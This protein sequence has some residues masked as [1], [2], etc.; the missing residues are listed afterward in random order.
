MIIIF[1][2]NLSMQDEVNGYHCICPPAFIGKNCEKKVDDCVNNPCQNA[3]HCTNLING[4]H[5]LCPHGFSGEF[6][7]VKDTLDLLEC[8]DGLNS[9]A[10]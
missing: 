3:G 9:R 4:F 6:C 5:C 8:L 7:E 1:F 10:T 2:F